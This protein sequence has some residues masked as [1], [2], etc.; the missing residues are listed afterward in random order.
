ME[1]DI[2]HLLRDR[3]S[4]RVYDEEHAVSAGYVDLLLEAARWA[5]S[6]GN[7]QPW[8]Y[9][10]FDERVPDAREIARACLN[11][12]NAVWAKYA[13]I[14]LLAVAQEIRAGGKPNPYAA[15][16][17]G[18]AN[19]SLLLQAI[20]L[21][22]NCRPMAGF[23]KGRAVENFNI[24]QGY[25][26][27]VMIAVGFAGE[28]EAVDETVRQKEAQPRTRNSIEMFAFHGGWDSDYNAQD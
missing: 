7:G 21:G 1:Q 5:P 19:Q 4:S 14:L 17:L 13:P 23:D 10:V 20:A 24:P 9:L 6:A 25:R 28:M 22:L 8:R 3:S 16:D 27:M 18:L 12:D 15:H 2:H 11:P 26:P